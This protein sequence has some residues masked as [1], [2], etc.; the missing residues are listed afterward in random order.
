MSEVTRA[1][2]AAVVETGIAKEDGI[3]EEVTIGEGGPVSEGVAVVEGAVTEGL[4]VVQEIVKPRHGQRR[5]WTY[6]QC[7]SQPS[8]P[9]RRRSLW[10]Y[11]LERD[12]ERNIS[13]IDER[14]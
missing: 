4:I 7:P 1:Q 12:N 3:A 11:G 10:A 8:G 2:E 14:W 6:G 13:P 5:S 9:S